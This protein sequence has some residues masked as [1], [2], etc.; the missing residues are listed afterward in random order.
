M[1]KE[2]EF[3]TICSQD[4]EIKNINGVPYF[5]VP[6]NESLDG[7]RA[8]PKFDGGVD[9]QKECE[10][11]KTSN[12]ELVNDIEQIGNEIKNLKAT[13]T[14]L[15]KTKSTMHTKKYVITKKRDRRKSNQISR[16]FSC[17]ICFKSYG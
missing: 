16:M 17:E 3:G 6:M 15:E 2:E 12:E 4:I 14:D 13:I 5:F 10:Y 11:L 8:V 1:L 7:S 9:Y